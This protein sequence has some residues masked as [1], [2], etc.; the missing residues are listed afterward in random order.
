MARLTAP[1]LVATMIQKVRKY[2]KRKIGM[3]FHITGYPDAVRWWKNRLHNIN[4]VPEYIVRHPRF[5]DLF[6]GK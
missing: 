3:V 6:N 1:I 4:R 5:S 2:A